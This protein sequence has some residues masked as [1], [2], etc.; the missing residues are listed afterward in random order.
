MKND[1]FKDNT[2]KY[3]ILR[4]LVHLLWGVMTCGFIVVTSLACNEKQGTDLKDLLVD[5]N[6]YII[7]DDGEEV[8]LP[9]KNEQSDTNLFVIQDFFEIVSV[10]DNTTTDPAMT[11]TAKSEIWLLLQSFNST[12]P[13]FF[14]LELQN[15]TLTENLKKLQER[16]TAKEFC[17]KNDKALVKSTGFYLYFSKI[18]YSQIL[19]N[20]NYNDAYVN[21]LD[22]LTNGKLQLLVNR[23]SHFSLTA[24]IL[25]S[26]NKG[27]LVIILDER[28]LTILTKTDYV[29]G[30]F[31][32]NGELTGYTVSPVIVKKDSLTCLPELENSLPDASSAWLNKTIDSIKIPATTAK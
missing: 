30:W 4:C 26:K 2:T 11:G 7:V 29:K 31:G 19:T 10:L 32:N 1:P 6:G 25:A 14:I 17:D 9:I 15:A 13:Q 28:G 3:T 5:A 12:G 20:D 16:F 8:I 27:R 24:K 21:K 18:H 23:V 22:S